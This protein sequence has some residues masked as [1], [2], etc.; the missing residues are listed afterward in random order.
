M[1]FKKFM[2]GIVAVGLVLAACSSPGTSANP[3]GSQPE[4]SARGVGAVAAYRLAT[5]TRC[6]G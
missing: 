2:G 6:S 3:S 5:S 1:Y 4:G